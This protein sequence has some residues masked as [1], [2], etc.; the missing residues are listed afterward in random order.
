MS[1]I[2]V[3]SEVKEALHRS[4]L[5]T[6]KRLR[7]VNEAI[8]MHNTHDFLYESRKF[9]IEKKKK[10]KSSSFTPFSEQHVF[11][12]TSVM[13]VYLHLTIFSISFSCSLF[14]R[15]FSMGSAATPVIPF[16]EGIHGTG[17]IHIHK[18]KH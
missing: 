10:V 1:S 17:L 3:I 11:I 15:V 2:P 16:R 8:R 12:F 13:F 6:S 18:R 9:T 14:S 7:G 5:C 4:S